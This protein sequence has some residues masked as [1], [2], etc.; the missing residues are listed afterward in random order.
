VKKNTGLHNILYIF[1][2]LDIN[3]CLMKHHIFSNFIL[4]FLTISMFLSYSCKHE[5]EFGGNIPIDPPGG[6]GSTTTS[7]S[8]DTAYFVQQVLPIFQSSCAMSGCHDAATHK[9]GFKL[10][11]YSNILATGG[12]KVNNPTDSKIYRVMIKSDEDIMPPSPAAPMS[13]TQ[14]AVIE[15]WISQGA[16]NNSCIESGCDT[17]NVKYSSHI[18]PL[19]QNACQGCHS[20][21]APGGGI[22]LATYAGVKAIADNG[23]FYG[24]ISHL[25]GYSAMPKNGN[26]LTECQIS[27]VKIWI[28][29]GAPQN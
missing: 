5:P 29:Q 14:L 23:K 13:G 8:P 7:C 1:K 15:K 22:D 25:S 18:K 11:N 21:S 6:N 4:T 26:K 12:I 28:N 17:T 2:L 24:S 10:D 9:E 16:R 19:I 27:M 3:S 20:G